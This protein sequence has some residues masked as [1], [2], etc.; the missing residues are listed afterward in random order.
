MNSIHV[1]LAEQAGL[2]F[3]PA[4]PFRS[5]NFL[6]AGADAAMKVSVSGPV[7]GFAFGVQEQRLSLAG[8]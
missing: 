6:G 4:A 8:D 5:A 3:R 1:S 7:L 2:A